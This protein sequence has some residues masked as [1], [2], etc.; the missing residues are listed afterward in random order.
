MCLD[1]VGC[2]CWQQQLLLLL[3]LVSSVRLS[4]RDESVTSLHADWSDLIVTRRSTR[5]H[6]TEL[7]TFIVS[8]TAQAIELNH[9]VRLLHL[10]T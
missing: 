6:W 9:H 5:L 2:G 4:R 10:H 7:N 8:I 3:L 1:V